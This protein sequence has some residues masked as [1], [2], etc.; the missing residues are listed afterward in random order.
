MGLLDPI[1]HIW[2]LPCERMVKYHGR[3]FEFVPLAVGIGAPTISLAGIKTHEEKIEKA[4]GSAEQLMVTK[5][6]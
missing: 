5:K 1:R 2:G 3:T 4:G 6:A